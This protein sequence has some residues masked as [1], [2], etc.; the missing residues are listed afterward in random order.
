MVITSRGQSRNKGGR[1]SCESNGFVSTYQLFRT[2]FRRTIPFHYTLSSKSDEGVSDPGYR[3]CV[4]VDLSLI[5]VIIVVIIIIIIIE[6]VISRLCLTHP[7]IVEYWRDSSDYY[8]YYNNNDEP[9]E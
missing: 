8:Y 9:N 4:S 5:T 3:R 2:V 6:D 1:Q 7:Q